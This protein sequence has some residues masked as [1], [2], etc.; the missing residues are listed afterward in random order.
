M[1]SWELV[2]PYIHCHITIVIIII[3]III[4]ITIVITVFNLHRVKKKQRET[5]RGWRKPQFLF[6]E[7]VL[8]FLR[9]S[10]KICPQEPLFLD[11]DTISGSVTDSN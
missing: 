1:T 11:S 2:I 8:K 3:I 4:I 7:F 9:I 5:E 10:G 6:R